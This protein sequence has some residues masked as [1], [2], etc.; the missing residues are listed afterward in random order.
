MTIS[1][2]DKK[3]LQRAMQS[4]KPLHCPICKKKAFQKPKE[5]AGDYVC[6][7]CQSLVSWNGELVKRGTALEENADREMGIVSKEDRE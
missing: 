3:R 5:L 6:V 7:F 1:Q 4:L 2:S